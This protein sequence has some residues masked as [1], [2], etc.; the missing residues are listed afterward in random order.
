MASLQSKRVAVIMPVY[1]A[2]DY[3]R[4]AVESVLGQTHHAL[5]LIAID[6]GS[7]DGSGKLLD[8]LAQGDGR[9]QV[10]HQENRGAVETL[11]RGL[12]VV[13]QSDA[14]FVAIMHADDLCLPARLEKQIAYL[15]ANPLI[16][17]CGTWIRT[18]GGAVEEERRFP[19][20]PRFTK[21]FLLFW[22]CFAH[23]T[24]MLRRHVI[25]GGLR[26]DPA[27]PMPC[28]DYGLW[29][30]ASRRYQMGNVPEV[31]LRYREHASQNGTLH[32][33]K[34]AVLTEHIRR[35]QLEWLGVVPTAEEMMLHQRLAES[36]FTGTWIFTQDAGEWLERLCRTNV[37][38]QVYNAEAFVKVLGGRWA[39]VCIDA[40]ARA[41]QGDKKIIWKMFW[42]SPLAAAVDRSLEKNR[43]IPD[44][45]GF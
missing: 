22:C 35:R 15:E 19:G 12:D 9:I 30:L 10:L 3:L 26:Y 40:A 28:E 5:K 34:T 17:L 32:R 13:V 4:Q 27:I 2:A 14:D 7:T 1:Q 21:P 44:Q 20:D 8:E 36:E 42:D 6:D 25:N 29:A 45:T 23:P 37:D 31:L 39:A 38:S 16:D 24:M 18:F 11:N 33:A 41:S 43:S